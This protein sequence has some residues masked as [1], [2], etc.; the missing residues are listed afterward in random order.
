[1]GAGGN[2]RARRG[3]E[4]VSLRRLALAC[5]IAVLAALGSAASASAANLFSKVPGTMFEGRYAPAAALLPEGKVL[6]AGGFGREAVP[7]KSAETY[8]PATGKFELLPAEMVAAH[9]E[10]ATVALPDGSVL[11]AGGFSS[12]TKT[13]KTGELFNPVT[14]SF[15]KVGSE[16]VVERDA[17]GAVLLPSGKVFITGGTQETGPNTLT[18]EL[19]DPATR[20]FSPVKGLAFEGRYL[21]TVGLLPSGKVLIAGG[22]N[23]ELPPPNKY[24]KTA[25]LFDPATETFQK[26]EGASHEPVEPRAEAGAVTLQNGKV[27]IAGGFNESTKESEALATAEVFDYNTNTFTKIP[28]VLNEPRDGDT[29]VLLPDGRALFI[30]GYNG[31]LSGGARWLST[32]EITSV[33]A[34]TPATG[35]ASGVGITTR[36]SRARS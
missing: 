31:A 11:L 23:G 32:I 10:M 35:A 6:I 18:A 16:M 15:E 7:Q 26:L 25:E 29:G 12:A 21:P 2:K 13:L 8:D 22:Y 20:S 3:R 36:T 17:P 1:M 27:L 19:Y 5:S 14:R 33:P 9:G 30:G 28:D 4:G 24:M 34:A